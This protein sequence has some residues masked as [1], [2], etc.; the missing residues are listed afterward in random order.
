M[1]ADAPL[2]LP[3]FGAP[4]FVN[5]SIAFTLLAT[6]PAYAQVGGGQSLKG[7]TLH[8]GNTT[9]SFNRQGAVV[10]HEDGQSTWRA[11]PDEVV[12]ARNGFSL[13]VD[14]QDAFKVSYRYGE[15][16]YGDRR[17]AVQ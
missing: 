5:I 11:R 10:V 4:Y 17:C 9:I 8:C 15:Y 14:A 16:W 7:K 6:V 3:R 2:E 13:D 1:G 12:F